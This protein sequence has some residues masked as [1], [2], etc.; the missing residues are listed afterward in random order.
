VLAC[1]AASIIRP[2]ILQLALVLLLLDTAKPYLFENWVRPLKGPTSI[3]RTSRD[4][5]YFND[6]HAWNIQEKYQ[7]EVDAAARS[8]C[9]LIGIDINELQLE[10]PFEALLRERNPEVQFV[11]VNVMNQSKKYE[12]PDQPEPCRIVKL[13]ETR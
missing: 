13:Q 1:P 4:S 5:Q 7:E 6:L 2:K 9:S 12:R 3:L 11:H 10:Y 8:G